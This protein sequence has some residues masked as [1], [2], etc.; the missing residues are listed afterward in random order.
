MKPIVICALYKFTALDHYK[1]LREPLRE[2]MEQHGIR[3][4]DVMQRPDIR[5]DI[6]IY[7]IPD[8]ALSPLHLDTL[9]L[10]R[11]HAASSV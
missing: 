2:F 5:T 3:A 7:S 11:D 10:I 9:D 6:G 1:S 4:L 8:A